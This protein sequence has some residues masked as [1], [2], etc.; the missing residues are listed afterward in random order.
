MRFAD[1]ADCDK[2]RQSD[3]YNILDALGVFG[4]FNDKL[5]I[6]RGL[7]AVTSALI[8]YGIQN[9]KE[10]QTRT[11]IE[12]F[13]VGQSPN[14]GTLVT[15]FLSLYVF[16]GETCINIREAVLLMSDSQ[17]HGKKVLRRLYLVV[18]VLEQAGIIEHGYAYSN[19]VLRQ[20]LDVIISAIFQEVPNLNMFPEESVEVLLNRLD[21]VYIRTAHMHRQEMYQFALKRFDA[22][23]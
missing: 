22:Q 17:E 3:L 10:A 13:R 2:R 5:V 9:E 4:H 18:F 15:K 23:Q 6:W 21:K 7:R 11:I 8:R 12:I 16:L 20:P 14:L 19:Y 1:V